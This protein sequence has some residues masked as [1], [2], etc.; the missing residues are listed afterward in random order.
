[1]WTDENQ[2]RRQKPEQQEEEEEEEKRTGERRRDGCRRLLQIKLDRFLIEL[3]PLLLLNL[4]FFPSS[5]SSS[6]RWQNAYHRGNPL[7]TTATH[8]ITVRC[9]KNSHF[10]GDRPATI[11]EPHILTVAFC[12]HCTAICRSHYTHA[13]MHAKLYTMEAQSLKLLETF[14]FDA[15]GCSCHDISVQ[16]KSFPS[17]II[18]KQSLS[19]QP[20]HD[21]PCACNPIA[22][23]ICSKS[24]NKIKE[25]FAACLWQHMSHY[26]ER[27]HYYMPQCLA[28][29]T[30]PLQPVVNIWK[31][32]AVKWCCVNNTVVSQYTS[33]WLNI[34]FS[35]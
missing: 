11:S 35:I 23:Q 10:S 9:T 19:S 2:G 20:I 15:G 34:N 21:T 31:I 7:I 30:G 27:F 32:L 25:E 16:R 28:C 5:S 6:V 29:A 26:V 3:S 4:L 8:S 18:Y 22:A 14:N 13:H 12:F 24:T 1:M 33:F 17:L